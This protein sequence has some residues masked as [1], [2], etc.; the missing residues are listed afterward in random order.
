[1]CGLL[2]LQRT[3]AAAKTAPCRKKTKKKTL[4]THNTYCNVCLDFSLILFFPPQ[5]PLPHPPP[6]PPTCALTTKLQ[7]TASPLFLFLQ[8]PTSE[9][10]FQCRF[11]SIPL[12]H[13]SQQFILALL[14]KRYRVGSLVREEPGVVDNDFL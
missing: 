10:K 3:N 9:S 11:Y 6:R 8:L 2:T 7:D 5:I 14:V 12:F 1:M 13:S 4:S